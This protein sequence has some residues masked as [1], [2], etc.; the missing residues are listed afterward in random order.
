VNLAKDLTMLAASGRV[1][2]IGNRGTI[3]IDPRNAMAREAS[4]LGMTL[5]AAT[6]TDLVEI[7]AAAIAGLENGSLRP[8]VGQELPLADAARA[9]K[10]VMEPGAYGK[11]V[12]VP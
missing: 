4:I 1:V 9:H 5:S 10:L 11:I 7:H 12:I 6:E 8:I 3:E 2:V